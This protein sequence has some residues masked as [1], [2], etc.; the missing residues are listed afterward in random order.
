MDAGNAA[1]VKMHRAARR[2]ALTFGSLLLW[3]GMVSSAAAQPVTGHASTDDFLDVVFVGVAAEGRLG[4]AAGPDP[5]LVLA[6]DLTMPIQ[7]GQFVWQTGQSYGWSLGYQPESFGGRIEFRF[8]GALFTMPTATPF[9]SIYVLASAERPDTVIQVGSLVIGP[10]PGMGGGGTTIFETAMPGT[11]AKARA[12]G[13][14]TGL[15]VLRISNVALTDGFTLGGRVT[16][17]FDELD[18]PAGSELTFQVYLAVAPEVPGGGVDSDGDLVADP[19]DNCPYDPNPNQ[20]DFDDDDIGDACDNCPLDFNPDQVD[21]DGDG[22]GSACD[23]CAMDCT[24]TFPATGTCS[25]RDQMDSDGDGVGD[26]CDN[27]RLAANPGQEDRDGDGTGDACEANIV[28][29]DIGAPPPDPGGGGG[30]QQVVTDIDVSIECAQEVGSASVGLNL[31]GSGVNFVGF[32]GCDPPGDPSDPNTPVDNM[33]SCA[34]SGPPLLGQN[35][36]PTQ[37]FTLG[38]GITSGTVP[39]GM[40]ILRLFGSTATGGLLCTQQNVQNGDTVLLGKLQLEDYTGG[41]NPLSEAG[42]DTLGLSFLTGPPENGGEGSAIEA[43]LVIFRVNPPGAIDAVIEVRTA[44]GSPEGVYQLSVQSSQQI[45][46]LAVGLTMPGATKTNSRFGGC[47]VE[48]VAGADPALVADLRGCGSVA[49]APIGTNV[50]RPTRLV[51]PE[52]YTYT[53]GPSAG[54]APLEQ[55]TIYVALDSQASF[56]PNLAGLN[57]FGGDTLEFL[58]E[59]TFDAPSGAPQLTFTGITEALPGY[60][61]G[62]IQGPG[63]SIPPDNVALQSTFSPD[64]DTDNDGLPDENDRCL[65]LPNGGEGENLDS[66]GVA[67]VASPGVPG[68]RIGDF[69]TCGDPGRDGI[70]DNGVATTDAGL[71]IDDDVIGCQELLAGMPPP[72]PTAAERCQVLPGEP[73]TF[74]IVDLIV[75]ELETQLEDSGTGDPLAGSLQSCSDAD[76][77]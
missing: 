56:S 7:T 12:D 59:V 45:G 18:P 4:D 47:D 30:G 53:Y 10:S 37:S 32:G 33:Q 5:E 55:E 14:G 41:F 9:N 74:N 58:G 2:K 60:A 17:F 16:A 62:P 61:S 51:S 67:F 34:G 15:D 63:G 50:L 6:Q 22:A 76:P 40:V 19:D 71:P 26:R 57:G 3:L 23:N 48:P 66:G 72:D 36:D 28:R 35:V 52:V 69:C 64:L 70:V 68:D 44:V 13:N 77:L 54:P 20:A 75:I 8:Q 25:N 21:E 65:F 29:L 38:P 39:D 11:P 31:T 42:F 73:G 46:R 1:M 43:E 49:G 27:C 24:V